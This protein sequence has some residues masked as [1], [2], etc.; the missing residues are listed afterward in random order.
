MK[1]GKASKAKEAVVKTAIHQ[2]VFSKDAYTSKA[3]VEQWLADNGYRFNR[4]EETRKGFVVRGVAEDAFDKIDIV[5][6]ATGVTMKIGVLKAE[7]VDATEDDAEKTTEEV[8]AKGKS[9]TEGGPRGTLK[10]SGPGIR[11]DIQP[12]SPYGGVKKGEDDADALEGVEGVEDFREAISKMDTY[13]SKRNGVKSI[14]EVLKSGDPTIPGFY[15][16]SAGFAV[17]VGN[18]LK[19]DNAGEAELD[20]A[21]DEYATFV[22]RLYKCVSGTQKADREEFVAKAFDLSEDEDCID[23]EDIEKSDGEFV[24]EELD[25][26]E[27]AKIEEV[28]DEEI[29]KAEGEEESDDEDDEEDSEEEADDSDEDEADDSDEEDADEGEEEEDAGEVE[30]AVARVLRPT[31]RKLT[32]G[33]QT[34]LDGIQQSL[35]EMAKG[36]DDNFSQLASRVQAGEKRLVQLENIG[37]TPKGANPAESSDGSTV[38][39]SASGTGGDPSLRKLNRNLI[40]A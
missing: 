37:Q 14:R 10:V 12:P 29:E 33:I 21:L 17:V 24:D 31:L 20:A 23:E 34:A 36:A 11:P 15:D 32:G 2:I 4:V 30:K 26:E 8:E 40:G 22:R 35:G 1:H 38:R 18:I 19:D 3:G 39:K 13:E 27:V 28:L 6:Q 5:E 25:E 9:V 7:Y 16:V